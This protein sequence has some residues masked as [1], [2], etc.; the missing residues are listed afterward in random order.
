MNRIPCARLVLA[1]VVLALLVVTMAGAH[2]LDAPQG[3]H[4][5]GEEWLSTALRWVENLAGFRRATQDRDDRSAA[6]ASRQKTSNSTQGGSCI[7]P[8]GR[9]RPGL[10]E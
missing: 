6:P 5:T 8:Q 2:P 1:T 10:C 7:D 9:P 3:V 4:R